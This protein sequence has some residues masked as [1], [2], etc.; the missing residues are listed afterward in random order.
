MNLTNKLSSNMNNHIYSIPGQGG[1]T[2]GEC[3]SP[4]N[5]I[6]HKFVEQLANVVCDVMDVNH[7][8]RRIVKSLLV[9][10]MKNVI[11]DRS[12]RNPGMLQQYLAHELEEIADRLKRDLKIPKDVKVN[13][14]HSTHAKLS[15]ITQHIQENWVRKEDINSDGTFETIFEKEMQLEDCCNEARE[16]EG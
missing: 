9:R 15:D 16:S 6:E 13:H 10:S 8:E 12:D 3:D 14:N 4:R 5:D 2:K 7:N 11:A 1:E